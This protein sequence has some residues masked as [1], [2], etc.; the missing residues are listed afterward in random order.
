MFEVF[1]IT[2]RVVMSSVFTVLKYARGCSSSPTNL[3]SLPRQLCQAEGPVPGPLLQGFHIFLG[4]AYIRVYPLRVSTLGT[5]SLDLLEC[6]IPYSANGKYKPHQP[7][8]TTHSATFRR[9]AFGPRPAPKNLKP[10]PGMA[11]I[12]P[13][14]ALSFVGSITTFALAEQLLLSNTESVAYTAIFFR[15]PTTAIKAMA[16]FAGVA[17]GS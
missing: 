13:C 4:S 12:T 5:D 17:I 1:L 6:H 16:R 2:L 10:N 15:Y 7:R 8:S 9:L 3:Q 11:T 14:F